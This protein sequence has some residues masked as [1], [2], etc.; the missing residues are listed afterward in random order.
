VAV[1]S[2]DYTG[3]S[4]CQMTAPARASFRMVHAGQVGVFKLHIPVPIAALSVDR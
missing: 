3:G 2:L 4:G 1:P